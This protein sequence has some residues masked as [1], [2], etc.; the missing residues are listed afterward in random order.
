MRTVFSDVSV[1]H[2]EIVIHPTAVRISGYW[3]GEARIIGDVEIEGK[4]FTFNTVVQV[5]L[6]EVKDEQE[7]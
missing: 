6:D 7:N 5:K 3:F 4:K 2:E 1:S